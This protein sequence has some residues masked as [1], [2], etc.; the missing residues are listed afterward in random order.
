MDDI[1]KLRGPWPE[2]QAN[3][4]LVW[5][6]SVDDIFGC[7]VSILFGIYIVYLIGINWNQL[8]W[9]YQSRQDIS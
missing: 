4:L 9:M 5:P 3:E 6:H 1:G 7:V 2:V 8:N